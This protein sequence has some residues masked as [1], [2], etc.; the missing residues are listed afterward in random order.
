MAASIWLRLWQRQQDGILRRGFTF[1]RFHSANTGLIV[2]DIRVHEQRFIR[3]SDVIRI[4]FFFQRSTTYTTH[5][6]TAS[7]SH[8]HSLTA[9]SLASPTLS[10]RWTSSTSSTSSGRFYTVYGTVR[11]LTSLPPLF[12]ASKIPRDPQGPL[13]RFDGDV[14]PQAV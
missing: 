14:A 10:T 6:T 9:A 2:D 4:I 8:I 5:T 11:Y 13:V 1:S 7:Y 3:I 12:L